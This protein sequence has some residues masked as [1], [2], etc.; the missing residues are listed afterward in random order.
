MI[1]TMPDKSVRVTSRFPNGHSTVYFDLEHGEGFTLEQDR[2][3]SEICILRMLH[4]YRNFTARYGD[5]AEAAAE[6]AELTTMLADRHCPPPS[7]LSLLPAPSTSS[8]VAK[9]KGWGWKGVV[10][11]LA[12]GAIGTHYFTSLRMADN[13]AIHAAALGDALLRPGSRGDGDFIPPSRPLIP[14][15]P[16]LPPNLVAPA[17][18]QPPSRPPASAPSFGLQQ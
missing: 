1:H 8:G 5:P 10:A 13:S 16:A 14:P 6:F 7:S 11:G 17:R 2:C 9:R 3:L 18:Q 4:G 12:I 15:P